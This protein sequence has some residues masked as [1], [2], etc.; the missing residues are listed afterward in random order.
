MALPK[1]EVPTYELTLPSVDQQ[2]KYRP[3]LVKEEKLLMMAL[4]TGEDAAMKNATIDLVNA[5]TMGKTKSRR[6]TFIF[7]IEY[8]FLN[9]RAKSVGEVGKFQVICP[10]DKITLIPVEIDLT[11]LMYR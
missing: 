7:D 9:I 1:I 6:F 2:V 10:E 5:C 8:L 4:E 11:K 3:F